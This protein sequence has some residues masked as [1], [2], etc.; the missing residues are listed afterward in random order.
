MNKLLLLA[1]WPAFALA[2]TSVEYRISFPRAV[3]HEAEVTAT[4]R[5]IAGDTLHARMA[6]SSPGRYALHEFAKNVYNVHAMDSRGGELPVVRP[7]PSGW[8]V[9]AKGGVVKITYTV[10]GDHADGTYAGI[11]ET[12]AH[13]NMPAVFMRAK[14][15]E[16]APV[17]IRFDIPSG[18]NWKI[19]T[20]LAPTSDPAVFTAP[21]IYYF[22]DS[23]TELSAFDLRSWTVRSNDTAY[24]VRL[25]LHHAGNDSEAARYA[26]MAKA[27]VLEEKAFFGELPRFDYGTYTFIA[28]Y[29]PYINGDGMEHR[30]STIIESTRPLKINAL[31]NLGTLAHEFFHAW[32]VKRLRPKSLEPFDFDGADMSGELWFAEGFTNYYGGLAMVRAGMISTDKYAKSLA[33][34]I[35]AVEIYRG[36]DYGSAV[37]MSEQAPFVDAARSVDEQNKLNTFISYYPFGEAI[38]LGLDLTLRS[39]FHGVTL[40]SVMRLAYRRFGKPEIPYTNDDIRAVLADATANRRFA[41]DFFAKY[42][43]G[44]EIMDY[45]KL[46][47]KAGFLLRAVKEPRSSIGYANLRYEDGKALIDGPTVIGSPLYNAGLDRGDKIVRIDTSALS[48]KLAFDS[49]LAA[50]K[51]SDVATIEYESREGKKTAKLT[52]AAPSSLEVVPFE[53]DL[54]PVDSVMTGF[55]N[56]WLGNKAAEPLPDIERRCSVCKR[57]YPMSIEFCPYDGDTLKVMPH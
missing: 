50:H 41:E 8:D 25:A 38:A 31:D 9:P 36:R 49:L 22:M 20:Q 56:A 30:N 1:L 6:R 14:G 29:L 17:T 13:L 51:S 35:N 39:E 40:D 44:R 37:E 28:D 19:A 5:G 11:D 46:L 26:E 48:S 2:Q 16:K 7:D 43:Y 23:P 32:N 45:E 54:R 21:Q 52:F 47:A 3:H 53:Y 42:V 33:G 18:S 55:R 10:Y 34:C 27:I 15:A 57:T 24:T 12:H 4:W